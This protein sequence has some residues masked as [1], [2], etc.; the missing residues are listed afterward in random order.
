MSDETRTSAE[1]VERD[2]PE[3]LRLS[4]IAPGITVNDLQASLSWYCDVVGFHVAETFEHEGEVR[5]AALIAGVSQLMVSQDDW[6]KGRDRVKGQGLRLY[7]RTTQDVDEVAAAIKAR[8]GE[9]ASEPTDMP[10]GARVFN[11]VDPDGFQL[12][13]SSGG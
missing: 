3:S 6:A 13:I 2:R 9:L 7:L 12:T 1:H 11:L 8:G 10:W 5:G 4:S